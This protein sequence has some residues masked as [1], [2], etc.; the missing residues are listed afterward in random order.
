MLSASR[1]L[2]HN[3]RYEKAKCPSFVTLDEPIVM[4]VPS[5][6]LSFVGPLAMTDVAGGLM[7]FVA[8]LV[9][10]VLAESPYLLLLALPLG[11]ALAVLGACSIAFLRNSRP[12]GYLLHKCFAK[13]LVPNFKS[14]KNPFSYPS[15]VFGP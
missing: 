5:G 12:R 9:G 7:L 3:E 11:M 13:G 14:L 6:R 8:G 15:S 2:R 10:G 1:E 4:L